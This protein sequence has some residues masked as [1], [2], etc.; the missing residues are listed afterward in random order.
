VGD[1]IR[2]PARILQQGVTLTGAALG[3]ILG[4]NRMND[5]RSLWTTVDIGRSS[6]QHTNR[7]GRM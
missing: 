4:V 3:A 2:Q 5:S 6:T 7:R 1:G